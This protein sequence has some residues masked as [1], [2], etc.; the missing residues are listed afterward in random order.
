M[1]DIHSAQKSVFTNTLY[2]PHV[3][4]KKAKANESFLLSPPTPAHFSPPKTFNICITI[5]VITINK[6]KQYFDFH[7]ESI[8]KGWSSIEYAIQEIWYDTVLLTYLKILAK[9]N[10]LG[11]NKKKL[12]GQNHT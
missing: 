2:Q 6:R 4:P 8:S 9:Y 10:V 1:R 3:P 7:F 12:V 11:Q 5:S